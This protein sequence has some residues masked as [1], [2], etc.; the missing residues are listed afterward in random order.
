[1]TWS[2]PVPVGEDLTI[3]GPRGPWAS[4]FTAFE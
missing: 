1:M 4:R 3:L 2:L